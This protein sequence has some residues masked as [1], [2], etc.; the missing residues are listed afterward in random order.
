MFVRTIE[1]PIYCLDIVVSVVSDFEEINTKFKLDLEPQEGA[2]AFCFAS[3]HIG[4]LEIYLGFHPDY[5]DH[6]T[7]LHELVHVIAYLCKHRDIK[8][9]P[10]NDEPIAYFFGYV[11]ERILQIIEKYKNIK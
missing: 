9:D 2:K 5:L 4:K 6:D 10:D 8:F 7:I 3:D 11:G 1:V